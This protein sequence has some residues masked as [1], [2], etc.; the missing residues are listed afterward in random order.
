MSIK[1]PIN[2]LELKLANIHI[3][4]LEIPSFQRKVSNYLVKIIKNSIEN[5]G[6][7]VPIIV[8]E[9]NGKFTVIDG[10]HRVLAIKKYFSDVK[11][12]P[13]IIVPKS[14]K[15]K[16]HY[17]N[18]HI[19]PNLKIAAL[20]QLKIYLYFAKSLPEREEI[21]LASTINPALVTLG[22]ALKIEDSLKASLIFPSLKK[23]DLLLPISIKEANQL[24]QK[25]AKL[26]VE[27]YK[28]V[29]NSIEN[30]SIILTNA[31]YAA[32][33]K[34][35]FDK[36]ADIFKTVKKIFLSSAT[37]VVE[38]LK[39]QNLPSLNEGFLL[40]FKLWSQEAIRRSQL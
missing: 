26:V 23:L 34:K 37:S 39:E 8:T 16:L 25:N 40:R 18:T 22:M 21:N 13:A 6:F 5:L 31:D 33:S 14:L 32:K 35:T 11:K 12:I 2:S 9:D 4:N 19:K 38:K 30:K 17:L 29:W 20:Q 10:Q 36:P 24:R 27:T 7:I 1:E 15:Y 28:K 3:D